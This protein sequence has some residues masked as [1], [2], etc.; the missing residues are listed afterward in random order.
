MHAEVIKVR[1]MRKFYL[2]PR[3][4]N[5]SRSA[6]PISCAM[7][8]DMT[9]FPGSS[10]GHDSDLLVSPAIAEIKDPSRRQTPGQAPR[11]AIF[12]TLN[13][14]AG[15]ICCSTVLWLVSRLVAI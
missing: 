11:R 13:L 4:F 14:W 9:R 10:A 5:A 6:S 1:C 2:A 15:R 3:V 12:G 8:N 7:A